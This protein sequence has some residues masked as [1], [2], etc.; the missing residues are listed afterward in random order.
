MRRFSKPQAL[1]ARHPY[2]IAVFES[3]I[4]E[5][6]KVLL[7]VPAV[8]IGHI[9]YRSSGISR[10]R[11]DSLLPPLNGP[12]CTM[13]RI[14]EKTAYTTLVPHFLAYLHDPDEFS[15]LHKLNPPGEPS[16]LV[17]LLRSA[18]DAGVSSRG[19]GSCAIYF[20]KFAEIYPVQCYASDRL[21][22]A[23]W[24]WSI[25]R[26]I[27]KSSP[28]ARRHGRARPSSMIQTLSSH[29]S[30]MRRSFSAP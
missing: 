17:P 29:G 8:L 18:L 6:S 9:I 28:R 23:T 24:A 12:W 30:R 3:Q 5:I 26:T 22:W 25:Y 10:S 7:Q 19:W 4:P 13:R 21:P 1:K 2:C 15:R 20:D 11:I 27:P 14:F 16:G